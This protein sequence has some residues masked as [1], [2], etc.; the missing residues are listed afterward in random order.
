MV[1]SIDRKRLN[2]WS[3]FLT[4]SDINGD[5]TPEQGVGGGEVNPFSLCSGVCIG[6]SSPKAD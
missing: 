2:T 1:Y 6:C 5:S 4:A 3:E